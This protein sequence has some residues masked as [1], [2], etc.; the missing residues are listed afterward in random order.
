MTTLISISK[1]LSR[2][3]GTQEEFTLEIPLFEDE[4]ITLGSNQKL[5]FVAYRIEDG[6]VFIT[7]P[8]T[9]KAKAQCVVTLKDFDLK[10]EL[11][12]IE[13]QFY[14]DLPEGVNP[15]DVE[16][17]DKKHYQVDLENVIREAVFLSLPTVIKSPEAEKLSLD[18]LAASKLNANSRQQGQ[19]PFAGLKD[20]LGE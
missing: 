18:K 1:L 13:R 20:M 12:P 6:L 8:T 9:L 4:E 10:Y 14:W 5:D 11:Q 3:I 19:N 16:F 2:D 17:I 7:Q 15:E